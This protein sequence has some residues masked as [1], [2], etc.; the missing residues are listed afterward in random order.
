M[1]SSARLATGQL[2]QVVLV[3]CSMTTMRGEAKTAPTKAS[4]NNDSKN[5]LTPLHSFLN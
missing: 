3:M 5:V 2:G 4:T 1:L